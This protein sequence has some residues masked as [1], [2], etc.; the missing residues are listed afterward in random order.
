NAGLKERSVPAQP[1]S[2][3]PEETVQP[4]ENSYVE[5]DHKTADI[6]LEEEIQSVLRE[7]LHSQ[8]GETH[9][10]VDE[11]VSDQWQV[12]EETHGETFEAP[13]RDDMLREF[14]PEI[15]EAYE[16]PDSVQKDADLMVDDVGAVESES[17]E[18]PALDDYVADLEE[19]VSDPDTPGDSEIMPE[20]A[21]EHY[22]ED[23]VHDDYSEDQEEMNEEFDIAKDL[24]GIESK[25]TEDDV[26]IEPEESE[27]PVKPEDYSDDVQVDT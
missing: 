23:R 13:A 8:P 25:Q 12:K 26:V 1:T 4:A 3:E 15:P 18:I 21:M 14:E 16:T 11:S 6:E 20:E 17:Y 9:E 10:D 19:R 22:A 27:K 24:P 7:A 5:P 2:P